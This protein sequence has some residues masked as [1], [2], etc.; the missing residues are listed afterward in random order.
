[1]I[2]R[3]AFLLGFPGGVLAGGKVHVGSQTNAWNID[4]NNL[5]S[6]LEVLAAL[7]RLGFEGFETG[8]R[9][10]QP[11]FEKPQAARD[12]LRESGLRFLG[13]HVFL[14]SYNPQTAIG[15]WDLL[16]SV[17]DGGKAL[18]AERLI[19]SGGSTLDPVALS[20]KAK[21]LDRVGRYCHDRGMKFGYHNHD[22]E[23]RNDGFQIETLLRETDPSLV[24]L[25]MDAGHAMEGGANVA[26]FFSRR[27]SRIDGLHLRD[28]RQG[29]EVILGQGDY[30]WRP[31]AAAI[32]KAGWNG[33]V[34]TEEER[35][36]GEKLGERAVGPAREAVR[37]IFGA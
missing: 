27:F 36:S 4:P 13:I 22:A 17:A 9:N 15:P 31:L 26:E 2:R 5:N 35:I 23:F 37:R 33:W 24:H 8:F 11:Q 16:R 19:V 20:R 18:G 25:V 14:T 21:A 34:L 32:G 30:D 3:R 10:L 6:L 12:R 28:A 1:M 7:R 29:K